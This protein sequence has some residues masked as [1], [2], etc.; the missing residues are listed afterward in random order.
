MQVGSLTD[1]VTVTA[2]A[3]L[4]KTE[5][6]ELSHE[7]TVT[8]MQEL[9]ILSVGGGGSSATS[10]FRNPWSVALLIPGTQFNSNSSMHVNGSTATSYAIRLEGMDAQMDGASIIYTQRVQPSVDAVQEVAI[11]TSN[12]AAEFGT[13]GGGLFNVSMRSRSNQYHGNP[14]DYM[15]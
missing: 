10:G 12:F 8:Q 5:S 2:E 9:P 13:V 14:Y 15:G 3:S 6:G 1:S 7:V 11:Q 4:L